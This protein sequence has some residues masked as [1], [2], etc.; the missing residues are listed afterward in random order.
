MLI[1]FN[2]SYAGRQFIR[3]IL[4]Y[5]ML[6]KLKYKYSIWAFVFLHNLRKT[7]D[8]KID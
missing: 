2:V 3:N 4:I 1:I 8:S 6:L 5:F 7:D